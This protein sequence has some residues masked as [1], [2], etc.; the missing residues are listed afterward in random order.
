VLVDADG[1]EADDIGR[2]PH[3]P[4]E[5]GDSRVRRVD[6]QELVMCLA[7]LLDAVREGLEAPIFGLADRAAILLEDGAEALHKGLD[8][9]GR[10]ILACQEYLLIKRH[11][12]PFLRRCS[13][14]K[15]RM[16]ALEGKAQ[17]TLESG[18]T[19]GR[20]LRACRADCRRDPPFSLRPER[21]WWAVL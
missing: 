13:G 3:L 4:L 21:C 1:Q 18:D 9:L 10:D 19:G 7:V 5:L 14:A 8:L 20:L 2:E 6:V 11:G 16:G 15:P 17:E 12:S